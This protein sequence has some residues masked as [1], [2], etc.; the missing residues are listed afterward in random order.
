VVAGSGLFPREGSARVHNTSY[1]FDPDGRVVAVTRKVNLV[2]TQEDVL[3]LLPGSPDDLAVVD[4]P[5]GRVGTL[6]CYDGF[7]EPHTGGEPGWVRCGPVL[8]GLGATIVAQ[9]SANAWAWDAPWAFNEPGETLLRSEQ[10][11]AEGFAREMRD[12]VNV[13]YAVN[14]QLVG[15]EL[16]HVFEAPSLILGPAVGCWRRRRTRAP[17]TCCT[18]GSRTERADRPM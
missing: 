16:D 14:P 4:T 12:L 17:R 9:P 13:R 7:R 2:P 6:I 8:D 18:S 5:F 3:G 1:M 11:F 10:W 15:T